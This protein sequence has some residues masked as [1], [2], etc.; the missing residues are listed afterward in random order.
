VS[1]IWVLEKKFIIFY[2]I[3]KN[4]IENLFC[5]NNK[6]KKATEMP[7]VIEL[8]KLIKDLD[9]TAR[10]FGPRKDELERIYKCLISGGR[11]EEIYKE[12]KSEVK[13]NLPVHKLTVPQLRIAIK[14]I[15]F[16]APVWNMVRS[17]LETK[18]TD[19]RLWRQ[20]VMKLP[21]PITPVYGEKYKPRTISSEIKLIKIILNQENDIKQIKLWFKLAVMGEFKTRITEKET[22]EYIIRQVAIQLRYINMDL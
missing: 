17:Q 10:V 15:D 12:V 9:P 13:I 14:E 18:L 11:V 2:N 20:Y 5:S 3:Y 8:R 4:K 1:V 19:L 22:E 16:E 21:D 7:N 6:I